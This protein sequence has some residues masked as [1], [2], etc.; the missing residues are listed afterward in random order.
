[1]TMIAN[2]VVEIGILVH[3]SHQLHEATS[4][5]STWRSRL[6]RDRGE[7]RRAAP[8]VVHGPCP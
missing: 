8:G 7:R 3:D 6:G 2:P 1:M 5:A 4:E